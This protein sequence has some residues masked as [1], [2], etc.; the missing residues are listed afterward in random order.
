MLTRSQTH[1]AFAVP[2][3]LAAIA[4]TVSGTGGLARARDDDDP[5]PDPRALRRAVGDYLSADDDAGRAAALAAAEAAGGARIPIGDLEEAV[6]KA[7]GGGF[8]KAKKGLVEGATEAA[9][10]LT[11]AGEVEVPPS[12]WRGYVPSKYNPRKAWP[13]LLALHPKGDDA[14]TYLQVWHVEAPKGAKLTRESK[15]LHQQ[16]EARGWL[17][18]AP[19][20]PAGHRWDEGDVAPA[21][22]LNALAT[23][24]RRYRVDPDRVVVEGFSSGASGAWRM[25]IFHADRLAAIVPRAGGVDPKLLGNL[26]GLPA[27][28][29]HG[30]TDDAVPFEWSKNAVEA[31]RAQ[32]KPADVVFAER[33]GG[34]DFF[35]DESEK[36]LRWADKKRREPYPVEVD[37]MARPGV[38]GSRGYWLEVARGYGLPRV[39]ARIDRAEN[40][41]AVEETDGVEAIRLHVS[42]RL[43]ELARTVK[44]TWNGETAFEG[45]VTRDLAGLLE[46]V[47]E[48]RDPGRVYSAVLE[49]EAP[50]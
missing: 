44:V 16:A 10:V 15:K 21:A 49:V 37:W 12:A 19:S 45:M 39:R 27:Y 32:P 22:A 41:I 29:V 24:A 36:I 14:A 4:I 48:T 33:D 31:L 46:H 25:G 17:V 50:K 18:L 47:A 8:K 35:A 23:F 30:K 7:L 20:V 2:V 1:L 34:H 9:K 3:A 26:T 13:L 5:A 38:A 42:E 43:L 6:G 11:P 28:V 40:T